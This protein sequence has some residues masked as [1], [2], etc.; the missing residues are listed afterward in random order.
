MRSDK[1]LAEA[2][3]LNRYREAVMACAV[4]NLRQASRVITAYF[5]DELRSS[6]LRATQLNL[7]MAIEIGAGETVTGLAE[8]LAMER[9]TMTRNLQLLR[10]R[11][12]IE[13]RRIALTP[14]GKRLAAAALPQW[15]RAQRTVVSA[16]GHKRWTA[17]LR[18]LESAKA[19]VRARR[20]DVC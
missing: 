4:M 13:P 9:T 18:E 2:R 8:V 16:L 12:L 10:R 20:P 6:G 11:G 3:V 19:S 15:E 1:G 5:D 17:L 7:L 14:Q